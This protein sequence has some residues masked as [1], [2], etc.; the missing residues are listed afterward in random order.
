LLANF[1]GIGWV[2]VVQLACV[3]FYI[4]LLGVEAYG[5]VGFYL[6]LQAA[7]LVLDLGLSPTINR[8]MARDSA[9]PRSST[10]LRDLAKTLEVGSWMIGSAMGAFL[11]VLAPVIAEHWINPESMSTERVTSAIAYMGV[12]LAIQWPLNVYQGGL[13]GLQRHLRPNIIRMLAATLSGGGS[14]VVLRAWSPDLPAFFTWQIIVAALQVLIMRSSFWAALPAAER[15]PRVDLRLVR[16]AV[17]FATGMSG[18]TLFATILVQMDKV[19]LS[20]M[21]PL[22]DFA[23]YVVAATVAGGLHLFVAP[24]YAAIFPR[25]SALVAISDETAIRRLYHEGTQLLTVMVVP[26]AA[27]LA[28]FQLEIVRA[29][30]GDAGIAGHVAPILGLL[31]VGMAI[32]GLMHMPYAL[33]LAYGWTS[34]GLT[35]TIAQVII[36]LPLLLWAAARFGGVGAACVWAL[37]NAAYLSIGI[38][39]THRRL[40]RGEA[41][42]WLW[43][44]V[45]VPATGAVLVALIGR[46]LV[47]ESASNTQA[48]LAVGT[49]L[50]TS[51]AAAFVLSPLAMQVATRMRQQGF[52]GRL[53]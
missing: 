12:L 22:G 31:A 24:V 40:L 7:L 48:L 18:I 4:R 14:I 45:C 52:H 44:D 37:L 53:P 15:R 8:E 51:S 28:L 34:I 39:W 6:T 3:P 13:L 35:L 2:A 36:F 25:L 50:V 38:P 49:I 29:W 5:L 1:A 27:V 19:V 41:L 11:F 16:P 30:T 26:V 10:E 43:S 46:M 23:Y 32:N 47:K 20:K 42:R 33:Q 21:L 9:C 17:G